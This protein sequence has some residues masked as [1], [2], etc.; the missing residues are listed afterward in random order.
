[1][2]A[3]STLIPKSGER[4]LLNPD[5][6]SGLSLGLS[7]CQPTSR[8]KIN[9]ASRD[10]H[11][12]PRITANA[13]STDHDIEEM[14]AAVKFLRKLAAQTPL[15][16]HIAEELRPGPACQTDNELIADIRQRSGTV[17]HPSCTC[18]MGTV[19]DERLQ[20]RGVSNL[21]VCDTS[22]F[23]TIISGNTNAAAMMAGWRAA[24]LILAG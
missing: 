5:P 6:F 1:M 18:A 3:F 17:Y 7:N 24:E 14:L 22:V 11:A 2:Q 16:Q 19:V 8:G 21:R 15:A 13:Y 20:V 10:P 4:P 23:P 12:V 9:I